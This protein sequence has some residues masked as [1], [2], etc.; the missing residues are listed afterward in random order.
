MDRNMFKEKLH[1][2]IDAKVPIIYIESFDDHRIEDILLEV[3]ERRIVVE[4]NEMDGYLCKKK[5]EAGKEIKVWREINSHYTLE[6]LL[7]T[8]VREEELDRRILIIKDIE[9]YLENPRIIALLKNACLRIEAGRLDTTLIFVSPIVKI[10]KELEKYVTLLQ[11]AFLSTDEIKTV[12]LE[13]L[14]EYSSL[15]EMSEEL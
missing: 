6:E 10:P 7:E 2:Y 4:W 1:N 8:G 3:T 12:I 14:Q 9:S 13:F 11:E 15:G 5:I